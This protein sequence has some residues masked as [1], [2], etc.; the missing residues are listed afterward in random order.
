MLSWRESDIKHV[1]DRAQAAL[2]DAA[3]SLRLKYEV[4]FPHVILRFPLSYSQNA[5][6]RKY[7]VVSDCH[8]NSA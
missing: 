5:H 1:L 2:E 3:V 7:V 4:L 8:V 6:A